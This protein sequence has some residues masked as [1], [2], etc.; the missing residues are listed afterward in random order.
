MLK[1]KDVMSRNIITVSEDTSAVELAKILYENRI[2]GA[3]VVDKQGRLVGVVSERDLLNIIF[4]GN[5]K[6]TKVSEI[7][8]K[9]PLS[10]TPDTD[11]DKI[12]LAISERGFRRVI[13][14]DNENKVVGIVSRHDIIKIILEQ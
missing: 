7:M 2:S 10:F 5:V 9:N 1:A 6:T 13:I 3:P 8:T 4:S 12:S 14:V 11:L